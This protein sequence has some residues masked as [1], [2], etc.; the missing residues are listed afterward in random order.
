MS[1][2]TQ[3]STS[4]RRSLEIIPNPEKNRRNRNE[5]SELFS[6]SNQQTLLPSLSTSTVTPHYVS[7]Y[8]YYPEPGPHRPFTS[9]VGNNAPHV[10]R[11]HSRVSIS[12]YQRLSDDSI[13][14]TG[15]YTRLTHQSQLHTP[16]EFIPLVYQGPTPMS[17]SGDP[18]QCPYTWCSSTFTRSGDLE[19]HLATA[20]MHNPTKADSSDSSKRCRKCGEEFSRP[21][22]RNRHELKNSCGKRK[23]TA[24]RTLQR[25]FV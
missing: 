13:L 11:E 3:L 16:P 12:N 9:S 20:S 7:A 22:A 14:E 4:E 19:R 2:A 23:H 25:D 6:D 5:Q 17:R 10:L 18:I 1:G 21:D 24:R 15:Q 8:P